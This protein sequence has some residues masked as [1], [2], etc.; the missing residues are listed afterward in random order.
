MNNFPYTYISCP[1]SDNQRPAWKREAPNPD[2]E[3][4]SDDEET[5]FQPSHRRSAFSLFPPEHLLYCEECQDIK[6]PRCVTEEIICW[7]CPSCLFE[8]PSSMVKSEGN[9]CARNCFNCPICTSQLITA[10][11]GNVRDGPFILNCN[12]CMWTSLEIGIQFEKPTNLRGQLDRIANGGGV[13]QPLKTSETGEA[14]RSS[15]LA[16]DPLS[17]AGEH[18]AK[19]EAAPTAEMDDT[20]RFKALRTFYKD[21]ITAVSSG[22][23]GLPASAL[24]LAY[25]SPS[26]LTRIMNLYSNLG[27]SGLKKSRS[28]PTVMREALTPVEGL[29]IPSH[30]NPAPPPT[31]YSDTTSTTQRLFQHPSY[32]GAPQPA[33]TTASLRPMPTLLRTK[34][35]KRCATC[36]HILVKPEFKPTS[37]RY[38]IKLIAL[39]Y[40]PFAILKPLPVSGGLRPS[41]TP[42]GGDVVLQPGKATQ[43]VLTLKNP[44]FENIKGRNWASVVIEVL[45]ATSLLG[46]ERELDEDEDVI[47][48][49]I[50]VRLEWRVGEEEGEGG[51]MKKSSEKA[52]EEVGD[53]DDGRRELSYWMVLGVGRVAA[54]AVAATAAAEEQQAQ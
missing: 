18:A 26:S 9:R 32:L 17:P 43:F 5:T 22:D 34:R 13:R 30:P 2:P 51:K 15:S 27:S 54:A 28:K 25:S 39:N 53:V 40:I 52:L 14:S 7:Y 3:T 4:S 46:L 19:D 44:Q 45:P 24:D 35:S 49:P 21:Q 8:T 36:K 20:A 38:R 23:S 47:E 48:V 1:C 10:S 50:R 16:K 6:C 11:V 42:D 41:T 37:T 29:L 12:Y 31:S 33:P